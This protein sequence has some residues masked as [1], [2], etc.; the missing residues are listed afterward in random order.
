MS[1]LA[2][3]FITIEKIGSVEMI[4]DVKGFLVDAGSIN[5]LIDCL[6]GIFF[7]PE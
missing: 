3:L 5:S 1:G 2:Y 4:D 7:N 6:K